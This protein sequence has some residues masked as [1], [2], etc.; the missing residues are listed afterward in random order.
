MPRECASFGSTIL[1][2]YR[3]I[4]V[5]P[6]KPVPTPRRNDPPLR[7]ARIKPTT[8]DQEFNALDAL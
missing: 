8:L 6:R 4:S 2:C 7:W 1:Y 5:G 3:H